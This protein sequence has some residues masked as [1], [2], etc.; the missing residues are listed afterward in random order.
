MK[1]KIFIIL[2]FGLLIFYF[3]P[4]K[5]IKE[6]PKTPQSPN[7]KNTIFGYQEYDEIIKTF[8]EWEN[9]C[10]DLIDIDS[11]GKTSLNSDIYFLKI[12]NEYNPSDKIVLITSCIHG[13]EPLSTSTLM[14][15]IANLINDYGKSEEITDLIN[16]RTI[17][18]VPVVSPDSYPYKRHVDGVDPNRNFSKN[19]VLPIDNL[20]KLFLEIKPKSVLSG[21]TYGRVFLIPWGDNTNKNPNHEDYKKIVSKMCEYSKYKY[22]RACE[23]YNKPIFGTEI[24][25]YHR[26][27]AFS[28][29]MEFGNHQKKPSL[30]ESKKEFEMTQEDILFFIKESTEI[31]IK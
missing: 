24:D 10:P 31:K 15:F 1:I 2:F 13:N 18:F 14:C 7:I 6:E 12:S 3:Y 29:V 16:T 5:D 28:I 21:H 19:S 20:K 11:Y 23:M 8:K 4:T 17:Y 25:W 27:G 30:D 26:N 22:Q 9:I